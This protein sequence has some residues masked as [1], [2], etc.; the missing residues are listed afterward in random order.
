MIEVVLN[1]STREG[2][3]KITIEKEK[4][5][6]GRGGEADYRFDDD[7][8][9]RLHA[10]VYRDREKVWIV[11]ENST[12][13][14]VVN[15]ERV[16]ATG[17]PLQNGD[18]IKIGN[19]TNI[20][21]KISNKQVST[22]KAFASRK[23]QTFNQPQTKTESVSLPNSSLFIPLAITAF[24]LLVVTA[25]AIFIGVQVFG[26]SDAIVYK[27]NETEFE[28]TESSGDEE[29]EKRAEKAPTPKKEK[30]AISAGA[31]NANL[32]D[33]PEAL[34]DGSRI[35]LP[36]GKQ[37]QAMSEDEKSRYIAFKAEKVARTIGN[38]A[39]EPIPAE[40]IMQ[41]KNSVNAY[42]SRVNSKPLGGCRFGDNLQITLERASRNSPFINRHFN[43]EG[44]EPQ[45]GIYV[46]MIESEHCPCL[47]SPT[48]AKGVFQFLA[49]TAPDYGLDP[50]QRCEPDPSAKAAAKYLKSLI[51][52]FG[53]AS[54][55]VPLAIAS[56]NSGQGHLSNNLDKV[57]A[58]AANQKRNFWTLVA[59]KSAMQGNAGKQ[60]ANENIK[61]VPKFF[62]AAIIG[63]NPQDFGL[64]LQPL[65]TYTK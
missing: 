36:N 57:F 10:S 7:G 33:S 29:D 47:E 5:S 31:S 60:F 17:T 12:N 15:G 52:R 30:T 61:Y 22:D 21:V 42:A 37:Y 55:S 20:K 43:A 39:S 35:A 28:T 41:I 2:S 9:S 51:G 44:I 59:N 1:C 8:L 16:S 65:S 63:E 46:A 58:A 64:N 53:T 19:Y 34:N 45:I 13:G 38:Q 18:A 4:T 3:Q 26:G 11:D 40:A 50:N 32:T 56:Y 48:H 14:T 6:F 23:A 25:S 27:S 62:A 49:S 24:A 54:D